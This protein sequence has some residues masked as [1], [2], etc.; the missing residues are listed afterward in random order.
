[1][2]GKW[3]V[4]DWIDDV[5]VLP[6]KSFYPTAVAKD[7]SLPLKLVFEYLLENVRDEKLHLLWEIR[8]PNLECVRTINLSSEKIT[9]G[10]ITCPICGEEAEI[11]PDIVYPIFSVTNEYKARMA[12]K[13]TTKQN[14]AFSMSRIWRNHCPCP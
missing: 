3:D 10:E 13:K 8:C 1:M 5:A 12:E 11:T 7:T 9:S 14:A 4:N 2:P 6:V